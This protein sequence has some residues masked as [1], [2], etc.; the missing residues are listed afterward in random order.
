[1]PRIIGTVTKFLFKSNFSIPA[2]GYI[3]EGGGELEH[4]RTRLLLQSILNCRMSISDSNY[5]TSQTEAIYIGFT[6][7]SRRDSKGIPR[8]CLA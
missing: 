3:E 2:R 7:I 8:K 1:M 5:S 6:L 4:Q